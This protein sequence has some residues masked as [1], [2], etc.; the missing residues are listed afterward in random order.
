M[1]VT[2]PNTDTNTAVFF[3][4]NAFARATRWLWPVVTAYSTYGVLLFAA[5]LLAGWWHARRSPD[6]R[7]V[8][9]AFWAPLGVLLAVAINQPIAAWVDSPRPFTLYPGILVLAAHSPD[10]G[11]PS[12]HAVM[13]GAVSAGLFLVRRG[14]SYLAGVAAI[15]LGFARVYVAAHFPADVLAGL[16][17]GAATT[18]FGYLVVRRVLSHLVEHAAAGPLRPLIT[19][20]TAPELDAAPTPAAHCRSEHSHGAPAA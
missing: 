6:R 13:A 2:D 11:L 8:V 1:T 17:L 9:A 20:R 7:V 16:A 12:D 4:V 3:V 10:P 18:L 15:L 5:L 19:A 14:L